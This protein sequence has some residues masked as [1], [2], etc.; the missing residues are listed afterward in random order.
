M[1][2]WGSF[3]TLL[4]GISVVNLPYLAYLYGFLIAPGALIDLNRYFVP[5]MI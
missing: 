3:S 1:K 5:L 4:S 2:N